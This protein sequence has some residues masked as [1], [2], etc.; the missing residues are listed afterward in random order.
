[1]WSTLPFLPL[2]DC[3]SGASSG[4]MPNSS[5]FAAFGHLT[6]DVLG[7]K[8]GTIAARNGNE[9]A[10][11][12]TVGGKN[13]KVRRGNGQLHVAKPVIAIR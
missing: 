2:F 1:M 8:S 9:V 10:M 4:R 3:V 12:G 11:D 13:G 5:R 6:V 7:G